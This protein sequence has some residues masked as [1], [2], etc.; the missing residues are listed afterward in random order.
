MEATRDLYRTLANV[1]VY[2]HNGSMA[3]AEQLLA[4]TADGE[5]FADIHAAARFFRDNLATKGLQ[6]L[7]ELYTAT[8]DLDPVCSPYIGYHLFGE[9]YK[10]GALMSRLKEVFREHDLDPGDELP[11]HIAWVLRYMAATADEVEYRD[12]NIYLLIP[13]LERMTKVFQEV[14]NPYAQILQSVLKLQERLE[15]GVTQHV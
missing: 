8:F 4:V 15:S 6:A 1:L 2:P 3:D 7:Q 11:D 10:R 9:A 13:A 12:A 5:G 14:P